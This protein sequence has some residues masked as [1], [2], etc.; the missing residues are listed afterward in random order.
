[1]SG[2][3]SGIRLGNIRLNDRTAAIIVPKDQLATLA[4]KLQT[5]GDACYFM[6]MD[7]GASCVD[8]ERF[9]QAHDIIEDLI[10]QVR[11][12]EVI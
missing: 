7:P 11:T 5:A 4:A 1:M 2:N 9:V 8:A 3:T 6:S 12:A 10:R